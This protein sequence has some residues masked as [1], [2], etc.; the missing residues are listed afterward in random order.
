MV[1]VPSTAGTICCA[2]A[3]LDVMA[4]KSGAITSAEAAMVESRGFLRRN[5]KRPVGNSTS[6]C[7]LFANPRRQSAW[8]IAA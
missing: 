7:N 5:M 3:N 2:W 1:F 4:L 6:I 8:A